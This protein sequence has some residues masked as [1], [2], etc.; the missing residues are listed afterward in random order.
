[1]T[2]LCNNQLLFQK[3]RHLKKWSEYNC[4]FIWLGTSALRRSLN[5]IRIS[6]SNTPTYCMTRLDSPFTCECVFVY[7]R[8]QGGN[9]P[10]CGCSL[11]WVYTDSVLSWNWTE[12]NN[13]LE[14]LK[15]NLYDSRKQ[16]YFTTL[17]INIQWTHPQTQ[18][19][20]MSISNGQ[21]KKNSE[22]G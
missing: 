21:H 11:H 1:M 6:Q 22:E 16:F 18:S 8:A 10:T 13:H 15:Y 17:L 2:G 7:I 19:T 20:Q 9:P 3:R 5:I 12:E 4:I 14:L